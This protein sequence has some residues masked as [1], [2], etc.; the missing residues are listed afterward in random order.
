MA[1]AI[2]LMVPTGIL[3]D[4]VHQPIE[5]LGMRLDGE[6]LR[7]RAGHRRDRQRIAA[8]IGTDVD[9]H[10]AF[11]GPAADEVALRL[12]EILRREQDTLLADIAERIEAELGPHRLGV[13][14]SIE[15]TQG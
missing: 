7:T 10:E 11:L 12:I 2:A 15:M 5:D 8:D 3:G 14:R 13:H 4:I 1:Q 6:D 9:E